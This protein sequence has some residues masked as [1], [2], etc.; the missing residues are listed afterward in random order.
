VSYLGH[1]IYPGKLAVAGKNTSALK[2]AK[3]PTTQSELRSF[4]G[5]SNVYRRFAPGFAKIA[6]PL[7]ALLRKGQSPQLSE[8]S[9]EKKVVFEKLRQNL[10]DPRILA[11][12]RA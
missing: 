11:L 10:L 8:L 5:L 4:V 3:F 1:V 12:P 9:L 6:A 2:T 7:N